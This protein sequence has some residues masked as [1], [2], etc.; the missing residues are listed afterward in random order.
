MDPNIYF[1]NCSYMNQKDL[2]EYS[3]FPRVG[4]G[5]SMM[6]GDEYSSEEV[7]E[8]DESPRGEHQAE[9]YIEEPQTDGLDAP[10]AELLDS[11]HTKERQDT[12]NIVYYIRSIKYGHN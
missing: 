8:D 6:T 12:S 4:F 3:Q 7:E 5:A 1:S 11:D 9:L 2:L 10:P